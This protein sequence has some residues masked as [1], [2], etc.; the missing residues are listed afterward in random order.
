MALSQMTFKDKIQIVWRSYQLDPQMEH[1][2]GQDIHDMLAEKK[3]QS[4]EWA[5]E[6]NAY[7]SNMA[8]EVGLNFQ[9]DK[10]IPTNTL[11]AHRLSHLAAKYNLQDQ[12]EER[13]FAAFFTEGKNIGDIET[14]SSLGQ[15]IGM[16]PAEIREVLKGNEYKEAVYGEQYFA[17]SIDIQGVPF[18]LINEKFGVSG[19]QPTEL[20]V[21]AL[22]HSY[23][24]WDE[25]NSKFEIDSAEGKVCT[26]EEGCDL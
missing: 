8:K 1:T 5:K 18:F 9:M 24:K 3:N 10:I 21:N 26:P 23:Q 12:L 17:Q 16:N 15:E 11:L 19:A 25:Q 13:L 22:N 14:L 6:M 2:P 7:V 4:R 20:F